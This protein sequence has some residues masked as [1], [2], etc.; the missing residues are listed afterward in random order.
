MASRPGGL[1]GRPPKCANFP[2]LFGTAL[3]LPLYH[4]V[5]EDFLTWCSKAHQVRYKFYFQLL[6]L[7]NKNKKPLLLFLNEK[8][9]PI[10]K[11]NTL[12]RSRKPM[13]IIILSREN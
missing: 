13:D 7:Q 11:I 9:N 5:S 4:S 6:I 8:E 12:L 2:L 1:A 10:L 3:F